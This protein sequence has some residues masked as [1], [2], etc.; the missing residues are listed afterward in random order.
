MVVFVYS[1]R[2]M[3]FRFLG[4]GTIIVDMKI[5]HNMENAMVFAHHIELK[6]RIPSQ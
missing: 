4:H 6:A 3:I 2:K 1:I 5:G